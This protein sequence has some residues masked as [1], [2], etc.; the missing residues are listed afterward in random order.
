MI[1]PLCERL[2]VAFETLAANSGK[3]VTALDNNTDVA[4]KVLKFRQELAVEDEPPVVEEA[5]AEQESPAPAKP[6]AKKTAKVKPVVEETPATEEDDGALVNEAQIEEGTNAVRSY[7]AAA[8]KAGLSKVT[9]KANFQ[10]V[11]DAFGVG[12]LKDLPASKFPDFLA[13]VKAMPLK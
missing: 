11:R 5:A 7:Y 13:A 8:D 12:V 4:L 9:Q 1:L 10:G 6:A 2:V 3:L